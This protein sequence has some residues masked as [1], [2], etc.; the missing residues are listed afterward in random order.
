MIIIC[1]QPNTNDQHV[2]LDQYQHPYLNPK[3]RTAATRHPF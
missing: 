2:F 1:D 3:Y